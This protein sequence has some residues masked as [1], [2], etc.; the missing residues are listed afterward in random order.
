MI[1]VV[2]TVRNG[3]PFLEENLVSVAAQGETERIHVVVDDGSTDGTAVWL[4]ANW[5]TRIELFLSAPVGR[6]RALNIG[7]RAVEAEFVA[8]LDADDAASPVWLQEM[9][10]VMRAHPQIDVLGCRGV[11]AKE[12]VENT[13]SDEV[14]PEILL[15]DRFLMMNPVHHSG[16]LIRRYALAKVNGYDESRKSLFDYA[17]WV[18]LMESGACI[19]NLD[20]AYI[21]RRI[22][23][24][25]HFES[26][27]RIAYLKGCFGL[28]RR[29]SASLLGGRGRLVPYLMFV[30]GLL[31]Q[32]LRHW[33]RYLR[34][35]CTTAGGG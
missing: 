18:D 35:Y 30:Y 2:T 8:I 1:A 26:R 12:H 20:R 27:K 15:A 32:Y 14:V 9:L 25:Q 29:V 28:R 22:H 19:A 31:P 5:Q 4:S 34:R 17:L 13:S 24:R 6:G 21:F 10:K 16:V 7:L 11:M 3:L 33:V 23:D